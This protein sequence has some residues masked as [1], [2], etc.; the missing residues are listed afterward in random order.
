MPSQRY[1]L[2]LAYR[3]STTKV[4]T[5][6]MAASKTAKALLWFKSTISQ[7]LTHRFS[8]VFKLYLRTKISTET[9]NR[10]TKPALHT[11]QYGRERKETK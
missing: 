4:L 5:E 1:H 10:K 2:L 11:N 8:P 7:N 9:N 6:R 3:D